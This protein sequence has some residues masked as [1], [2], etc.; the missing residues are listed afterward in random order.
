MRLIDADVLLEKFADLEATALDM[1]RRHMYDDD[2]T[3]WRRWSVILVERTAYK[4]DAFNA[5]T[6]DA[7]P[8]KHGK[9]IN[10]WS[11]CGSVWLEQSCSEC[12]LTFEDEPHEYKYCPNC[13][14]KMDVNLLKDDTNE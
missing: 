12:G 11:G 5:P 2:L 3:M 13:G 7:V 10:R 6:I 14:A 8:A 1:C 4:Y 9:W